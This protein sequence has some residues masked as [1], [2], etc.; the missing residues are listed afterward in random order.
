MGWETSTATHIYIFNVGRGNSAFIRTPLN[1]GFLLD[2]GNEG[3]EAGFSPAKFIKQNFLKKLDDYKEHKIAQAILSHPHEDHVTECEELYD[4]E[5]MRPTLVTCPHDK[6]G[7][8]KDEK[9]N[10][11]RIKNRDAELKK[12]YTTVYEGRKPPLQTIQYDSKLPVPPRLEYGIYYVRPPQVEKLHADDN[13]YGN[14]T[15]IVFYY[16]HGV[17]SILVP[18][19]ITPECMR[20]ILNEAEGTEKR[21]TKFD[22]RFTQEHPNWHEKSFDQPSLRFGLSTDGLSILVAPHHGLES[23]F[24]PE[25]FQVMRNNKPMLNIISEKRQLSESDGKV[26]DFY[27]KPDGASGLDIVCDGALERQRRS[28]STR[29]GHHIL[30]IFK[31]VGVPQVVL[32]KS[33]DNLVRIADG[34]AAAA[35]RAGK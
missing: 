2:M 18:G 11:N 26:H 29:N 12:R 1:Q 13:K 5:E 3:G 28:V 35:V 30:I 23:C 6:D 8:E 34:E 21:Y 31:G 19:D 20:Q 33:A 14:G 10:W 24:C 16:R 15:S 9:L 7:S 32:D 17:H 25:L 27:Q 4:G 22:R